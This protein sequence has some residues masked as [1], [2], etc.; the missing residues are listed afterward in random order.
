MSGRIGR[1]PLSP[2]LARTLAPGSFV[3]CLCLGKQERGPSHT[4]PSLC[5]VCWAP[6]WEGAVASGQL[7]GLALGANCS[8]KSVNELPTAPPLPGPA[9]CPQASLLS[10]GWERVSLSQTSP[11]ALHL[12]VKSNCGP[13]S[14]SRF[15]VALPLGS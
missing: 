6:S 13:C 3:Y 7:R 11:S 12:V 15:W 4:K 2:P 9:R 5:P 1:D 8:F 14:A 10:P